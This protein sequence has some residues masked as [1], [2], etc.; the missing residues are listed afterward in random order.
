[1]YRDRWD[2]ARDAL[3]PL[4]ATFRDIGDLPLVIAALYTLAEVV[5][6]LGHVDQ[7]RELATEALALA[8]REQFD[9]GVMWATRML[10]T[11]HAR[12]GNPEGAIALIYEGATFAS[13]RN[14]TAN[15]TDYLVDAV[16][17]A[18]ALDH[19][20]EAARLFAVA[21]A[22]IVAT[23]LASNW[24][25]EPEDRLRQLAIPLVGA[26]ALTQALDTGRKMTLDD[27]LGLVED[28]SRR[29]DRSLRRA[30]S[31]ITRDPAALA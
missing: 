6:E 11:A 23:G 5:L 31:G 16:N 2:E 18:L 25:D 24:L 15:L 3:I 14:D 29:H 20:L 28:L 22:T 30:G 8:Q 17:V 27:A 9:R 19:P 13:E 4:I 26:D 1:M 21:K 10:A 12:G 7:A